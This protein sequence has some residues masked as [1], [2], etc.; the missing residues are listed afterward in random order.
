MTDRERIEEEPPA[1]PAILFSP[2]NSCA[3][4]RGAIWGASFSEPS[5]PSF[6]PALVDR[7]TGSLAAR[8][9]VL[10]QP[11]ER[12]FGPRKRGTS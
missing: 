12:Q 11:S 1:T 3:W 5:T 10:E 7:R 4:R 9:G 6:N 8:T 2:W